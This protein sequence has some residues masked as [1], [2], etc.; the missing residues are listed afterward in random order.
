MA[1]CSADW[2]NQPLQDLEQAAASMQADRHE[3]ACFAAHQATEKALKALNLALG[4][5]ARQG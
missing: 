2:L 4:C 5:C 1:E 3:W